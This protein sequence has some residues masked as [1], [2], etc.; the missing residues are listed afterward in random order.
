MVEITGPVS[1]MVRLQDNRL[2]RRHLDHLRPRV[3]MEIETSSPLPEET[4][5][6]IELPLPQ[7][8][9]TETLETS[10]TSQSESSGP[11]IAN[12]PSAQTSGSNKTTTGDHSATTGQLETNTPTA[13]PP[14]EL[15]EARKTY[16]KRNRHRPNFYREF[17]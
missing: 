13:P 14:T 9:S 12:V 8:S 4:P 10:D 6:E 7:L 16:P 15:A 5:I 3:E 17:T 2:V 11:A 1:Y